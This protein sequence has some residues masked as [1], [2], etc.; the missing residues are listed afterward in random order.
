MSGKSTSGGAAEPSAVTESL[1]SRTILAPALFISF[2]ISLLVVDRATSTE[3]FSHN[4]D[5]DKHNDRRSSATLT[6]HTGDDRY[7]HSHQRKLMKREMED[8][9]AMRNRVIAAMM[10]CGALGVAIVGWS[11]V[12]LWEYIVSGRG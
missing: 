5:H 1:L 3:V 7:Y 4:A 10:V 11:G 12:K 6:G 9:F 8:A 2:L